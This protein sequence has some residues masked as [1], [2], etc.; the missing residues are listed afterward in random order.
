VIQ[1]GCGADWAWQIWVN[2]ELILDMMKDGDFTW[3][4]SKNNILVEIPVKKGKNIIAVP[5]LSGSVK[6][7]WY[8]GGLDKP[9]THAEMLAKRISYEKRIMKS[10]LRVQDGYYL[11]KNRLN[12]DMKQYITQNLGW[13][14]DI[15]LRSD[16]ECYGMTGS[17]AGQDV[18]WFHISSS[19]YAG[20]D[21]EAGKAAFTKVFNVF[22]DPKN[23][24]IDFHC[25]AGQDRT[26]AVAFI[27]N[28]LLGVPEDQLYLD[29][30]V[31]GFWNDDPTF[32]HANRFN[33]LVAAFSKYPGK[34]INERIE[35]YV[36]S[37]GFARKD[38]QFL[39]DFMLE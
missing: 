4:P 8:F 34:T 18:E 11:G 36:L 29:W 15:D 20:I 23:Y 28:G 7:V 2:G 5:L 10:L 39:R 25:I 26:G 1:A 17:P 12:D 38:I 37:L 3:P 22:L 31:T 35:N 30:E 21:S 19:A 32:N 6:W 33:K 14:S 24:P 16:R 13:K 9:V 27:I